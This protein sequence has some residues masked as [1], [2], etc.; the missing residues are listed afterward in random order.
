MLTLCIV[1]WFGSRG[2]SEE[3]AISNFE[4]ESPTNLTVVSSQ[5]AADRAIR[6]S[7]TV[8]P[9]SLSLP[10]WSSQGL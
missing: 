4:S 2:V 10:Q 8:S 5:L 7:G 6:L 9:C 3:Q 1:N